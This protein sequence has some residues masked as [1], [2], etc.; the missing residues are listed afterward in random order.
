MQHLEVGQTLAVEAVVLEVIQAH[1]LEMVEM[2]VLVSSLSLILLDKYSKQSTYI[3]ND[4][5]FCST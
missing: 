1:Q 2:V 4:G 3:K 5:S